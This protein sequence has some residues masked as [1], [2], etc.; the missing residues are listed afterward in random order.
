[1]LCGFSFVSSIRGFL[2][3]KN[4]EFLS[5][6]N[7]QEINLNRQNLHV[8]NNFNKLIKSEKIKT[9]I[10]NHKILLVFIFFANI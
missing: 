1:M 9:D 5:Q 6:K 2:L 10:K 8:Y 7:K 3:V 4:Q